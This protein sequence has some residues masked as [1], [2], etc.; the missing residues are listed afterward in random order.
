VD[1][2]VVGTLEEPFVGA[3]VRNGNGAPVAGVGNGIPVGE[4]D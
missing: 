2:F 1:G 3:C 4:N